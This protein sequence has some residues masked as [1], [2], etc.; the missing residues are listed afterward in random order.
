MF[1][2]ATFDPD[3]GKATRWRRGMPSPNPGGRPKSRLLSEALRAK[4]GEIDHDDPDARTHAEVLAANLIALAC[5]QGRS[6]VAAASEIAD[7]VEGRAHQSFDFADVTSDLRARSDAELQFFLSNGRWP[8]DGE[9][10]A[11]DAEPER[12]D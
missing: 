10:A 2:M 7:R 4:L 5:S 3:I 6:A 1:L 9:T 11:T 8:E 12:A